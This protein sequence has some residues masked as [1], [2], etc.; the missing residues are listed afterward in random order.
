MVVTTPGRFWAARASTVRQQW[1][2]VSRQSPGAAVTPH[3]VP[4]SRV[5]YG[6]SIW[7]MEELPAST[8]L[9]LSPEVRGRLQ[10]Y[11]RRTRRTLTA[12]A[13]MLLTAGL[14]LADEQESRRRGGAREGREEHEQ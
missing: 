13:E 1:G 6:G 12:S 7:P 9:R 5:L 14:D 4:P 10:D 2:L 3:G 8:N 11:A